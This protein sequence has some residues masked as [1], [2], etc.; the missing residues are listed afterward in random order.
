MS[1]LL[2]GA[3]ISGLPQ[4]GKVVVGFSGGADSTALAHWLLGRL[5]PERLVLAHVN[6]QLRGEESDRDE[7]AARAFVQRF[8]LD[9][10]LRRVDVAALARRRGL[11]LEECG[12]L[13][14]CEGVGPAEGF[15]VTGRTRRALEVEIR[16]RD[17]SEERNHTGKGKESK[18]ETNQ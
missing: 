15:Q 14:F 11:G 18:F 5:G 13:V 4:R 10:A 16:P 9:F 12:R 7:A 2:A 6:H 1:E 8:G 17:L 3:D